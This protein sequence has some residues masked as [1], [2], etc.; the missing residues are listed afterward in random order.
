MTLDDLVTQ[1]KAAHGSALL[2]V[3]VYGSTA[4]DAAA[5][6]DHNVLVVVRTLELPAMQAG[7]AIGRSWQ[8]A[9]NTV[10]LTLTAAEWESSVDVFAIEHADIAERNRVVF[11]AEGFAVSPRA[12]ISDADIRSQLEYESLAQVLSVR[13]GI[14]SVGRDAKQQRALLAA[15]SGRA[16]AL[17][18]AGVRLSGGAPAVDA[19]AVCAQAG[20]LAGF[21]P[22]PFVAAYR[23]RRG[24]AEVPKGD[25]EAVLGGFHA[26]LMRFVAHIDGKSVGK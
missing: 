14:T 4:G 7:G 18:R 26:G 3:V 20:T 15:Q 21:D 1:L 24:S 23:Q 12:S 25:L 16:V 10:P 6:K 2:G 13:A 19:E 5:K 17:F 22:A 8:E 11:A 9:G